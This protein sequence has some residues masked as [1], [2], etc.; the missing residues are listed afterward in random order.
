M[1]RSSSGPKEAEVVD[2][3]AGDGFGVG[4]VLERLHGEPS[5]VAD[6]AQG[7]RDGGVIDLAHAGAVEVRIVHVEMA[8]IVEMDGS[9][10]VGHAHTHRQAPKPPLAAATRGPLALA[11]HRLD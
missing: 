9:N 1:I 2:A 8:D 7:V 5:V 6:V 4:V 11:P 10:D 3:L